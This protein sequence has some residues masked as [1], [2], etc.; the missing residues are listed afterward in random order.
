MLDIKPRHSQDCILA[1]MHYP[2]ITATCC[3]YNRKKKAC[4]VY[5][6]SSLDSTTKDSDFE[7]F[8]IPKKV[9][10]HPSKGKF[11]LTCYE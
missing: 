7:C 2:D 10:N 1:C 8:F 5:G 9:V 3:E 11:S 4:F 6:Y